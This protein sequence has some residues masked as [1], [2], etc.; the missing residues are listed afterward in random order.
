V[1]GTREKHH[2]WV[3]DA[4][5]KI[6]EK[7]KAFIKSAACIKFKCWR[8]TLTISS[9]I[10]SEHL[11]PCIENR[12]PHSCVDLIINVIDEAHVGL[13]HALKHEDL[14]ND[15]KGCKCW[16]A[17]QLKQYWRELVQG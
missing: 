3:W 8:P 7:Y 6:K 14:D 10:M 9:Q 5:L 17:Q 13:A 1:N 2:L 12:A 15:L 11:C 4:C 16:C